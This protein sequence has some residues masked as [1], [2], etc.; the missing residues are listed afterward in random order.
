M[1]RLLRRPLAFSLFSLIVLAV[2]TA[3]V[4]ADE[5]AAKASDSTLAAV[6]VGTR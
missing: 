1:Q 6:P 2:V 3:N 4:R 5:P